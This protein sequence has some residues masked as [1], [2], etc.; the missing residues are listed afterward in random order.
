MLRN[1]FVYDLLYII[2][3]FTANNFPPFLLSMANVSAFLARANL[4]LH[5]AMYLI[6]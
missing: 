5:K 2:L 6:T 3:A 4:Y 1:F